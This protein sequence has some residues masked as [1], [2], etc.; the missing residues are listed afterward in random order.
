MN[1]RLV[2]PDRLRKVKENQPWM[3]S[4]IS[5]KGGVGK[6]VIAFNLAMVA[7]NAGQR[8]LLLDAD[9]YFGNQHILANVIPEFTL[10]DV[11][12]DY[13]AAKRAVISINNNLHL[14]A[15][16]AAGKNQPEFVIKSF[17]SLMANLRRIFDKYD[18]IIVDTP[19][20]IVDLINL[21]SNASDMNLIVLIPELTSI[22]DSFGLFKYLVKSNSRIAAHILSNRVQ[23]RGEYEYIYQKLV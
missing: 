8:C 19:S 5:G 11:I 9:W 16:P 7:A 14:I 12:D 3:V 22:A 2:N 6:S 10:A 20:G 15:S 23:N 4:L 13:S 18:F 21:T 17:A 1:N